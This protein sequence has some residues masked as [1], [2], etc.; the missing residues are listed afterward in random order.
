V[1]HSSDGETQQP[2]QSSHFA[3]RVGH[4][5][6]TKS[7]ASNKKSIKDRWDCIAC[8]F[9]E[10]LDAL[11]E[12]LKEMIISMERYH[13]LEVMFVYLLEERHTCPVCNRCVFSNKWPE[14]HCS[15]SMAFLVLTSLRR[16][17][18][19]LIQPTSLF[20]RD[21]CSVLWLHSSFSVKCAASPDGLAHRMAQ[22]L[23]CQKLERATPNDR[24]ASKRGCR[25]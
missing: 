8:R 3:R 9:Y 15:S 22:C 6:E 24:D 20:R 10:H 13:G 12:S 11:D 21:L 1:Q 2:I 19:L 18:L 23:I 7:D 4:E 14:S 16:P 5:L 25:G 17:L